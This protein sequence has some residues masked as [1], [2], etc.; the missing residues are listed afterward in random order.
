MHGARAEKKRWD[1]R[2]SRIHGYGVF[3]TQGIRAG[4]KILE[5]TGERISPDE[6]ERRYDDESSDRAH[7]LLFTVD[8]KTVIDGGA[9]GGEARFVNHSCEP[10]CEA[11]VRRGRIFIVA[12][13]SIAPGEE[14]TYDYLLDLPGR[15]TA[16]VKR[17]Y[18]CRCGAASCRG[19][20]LAPKKG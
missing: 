1:V 8:E 3:A 16:A 12:L 17:R 10:N 14:L 7:V 6:A 19:T 9:G 15:H 4:T 20:L 11:V 13:R 2:F 18:P 5:Y